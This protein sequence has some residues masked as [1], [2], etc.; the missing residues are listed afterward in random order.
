MHASA[1]ANVLADFDLAN[2][3]EALL[4]DKLAREIRV[5]IKRKKLMQAEGYP[6]SAIMTCFRPPSAGLQA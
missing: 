3:K 6:R 5:I 2:P 1:A 4:K